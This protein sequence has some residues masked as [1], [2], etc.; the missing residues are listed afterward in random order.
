VWKDQPYDCK[1]DIWS[2]GCVLYE[3]AALKPPFRAENMEGL[4]NKVIKGNLIFKLGNITRISDKYSSDLF[5][6]IKMLLQVHPDN[7]PTCG[8][9]IFI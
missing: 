5:E 9:D 8:M 7:R 3:M 6:V 1:S 4:Y 2:L